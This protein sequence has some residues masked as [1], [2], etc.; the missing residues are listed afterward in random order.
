[1]K[2]TKARLKE[3]IREELETITDNKD[4]IEEPPFDWRSWLTGLAKDAFGGTERDEM[5]HA[6]RRAELDAE[7]AAQILGPSS[8]FPSADPAP[9]K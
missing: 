5:G 3:M 6:E 4:P 9:K 2:L 7:A 8:M 1:M